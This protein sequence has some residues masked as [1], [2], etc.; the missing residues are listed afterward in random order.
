MKSLIS[1][2]MSFT[3]VTHLEYGY[4]RSAS[5]QGDVY[6]F[7]VLALKIVT[8]KRPTYDMFS[9]DLSLHRWVKNHYHSQ[10]DMV[11]DSSLIKDMG[12]EP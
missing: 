5:T 7:G 12:S 10:L 1:F 6:S 9:E 11:I 4:G 2:K 3:Y 8:R